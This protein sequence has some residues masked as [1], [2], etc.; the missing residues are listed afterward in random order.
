MKTY[1]T[2]Q[3]AALIGVHPNTV[4]F[5]EQIGLLPA[6]PRAKNGYRVFDDRHLAQLQLLRT[7]FRAEILSD[8]LRQEAYEIVKTAAAGAADGAYR[9]AARYRER[10]REERARAEEAIRIA[11]DILENTNTPDE[12]PLF[13]SRREV[14]GALGVTVNVLRDWERNGL[15]RIPRTPGGRR[16]YRSKEMSRLKIIR[17]LRNAHYSMMSILRMLIR[18]D[19]GNRNLRATINMPGEEE[20]IVH[21]TDRYISSLAMA[22]RDATEILDMLGQGVE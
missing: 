7:A 9:R 22:E 19:R 12:A 21:A 2:A 17:T 5:Y 18:L 11:Q 8:R 14:A 20:D 4:R 3:I 15:V 6:V 13:G 1:S 10:L 16:Q